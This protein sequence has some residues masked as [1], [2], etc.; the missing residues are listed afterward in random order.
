MVIDIL[1]Q[2]HIVFIFQIVDPWGTVLAQCKEGTDLA[3]A[4]IDLDSINRIRR[5]MPVWN[6]RRTDLY[7]KIVPLTATSGKKR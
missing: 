2:N 1:I 7:P 4:E 6:H 5:D 3:I